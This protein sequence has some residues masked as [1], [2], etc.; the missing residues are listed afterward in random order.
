MK[1]IAAS[2]QVS[3]LVPATRT[4]TATGGTVDVTDYVGRLKMIQHVGAVTGTNPTLTGTVEDSPD[5]VSDW[6]TV[7]TFTVVTAANNIQAV[8][9]VKRG[10]RRWI[11][12][13]AS[14]AGTSPNFACAAVLVAYKKRA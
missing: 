9:L 4:V 2:E 12:Y 14:L 1:D 10:L 3:C 8:G 13:K 11:R 5:G 7:A 6:Q